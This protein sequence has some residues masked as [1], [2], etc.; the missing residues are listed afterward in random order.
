MKVL[1]VGHAYTVSANRQKIH[2]INNKFNIDTAI[3]TPGKWKSIM[4][5]EFQLKKI[6]KKIYIICL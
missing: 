5:K 4:T 1:F 6:L 2:V 3:I